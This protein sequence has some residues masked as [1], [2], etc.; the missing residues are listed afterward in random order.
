MGKYFIGIV[1]IGLLYSTGCK[2]NDNETPGPVKDTTKREL[3]R[4]ILWDNGTTATMEYSTDSNLLKIN[5]RFQNI[6]ST[7]VFNWDGKQFKEIYDDRSLYKNVFYYN[8]SRVSHY[9]NK[10]REMSIFNSYSMEYGYSPSGKLTTLKHYTTN[11]QGT[12]LQST[13]QYQYTTGGELLSVTTQSGNSVFTHVIESFSEEIN[14]NPLIY[15]EPTLSENYTV[16]N[17]PVLSS[18]NKLPKKIIRKVKIGSAEEY[19]DKIEETVFEIAD[20]RL[21]KMT[22]TI[23]IPGMPQYTNTISGVFKY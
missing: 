9:I 14:F 17:L 19:V 21:N 15:I 7:T 12:A 10:A 11:E 6:V 2:K 5:Y 16:Y 18:V 13:S 22:T 20:K 3:V 23:T 4:S 8:G 1:L